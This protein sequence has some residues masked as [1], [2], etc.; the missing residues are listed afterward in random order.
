[1]QKTVLVAFTVAFAVSQEC[2]SKLARAELLLSPCDGSLPSDIKMGLLSDRLDLSWCPGLSETLGQF[3][4]SS[5]ATELPFGPAGAFDS[6]ALRLPSPENRSNPL[7]PS[8]GNV[9]LDRDLS[10]W[11]L[12]SLLSAADPTD[13]LGPAMDRLF[14]PLPQ[15]HSSF[16][17]LSRLMNSLTSTEAE[18]VT[19]GSLGARFA[20]PNR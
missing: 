6:F 14:L 10:G 7:P 11:G 9:G 13:D 12:V 5:R 1:M 4:A 15:T 16:P 2:A 19:S 17:G 3:P 8:S 20:S 18:P